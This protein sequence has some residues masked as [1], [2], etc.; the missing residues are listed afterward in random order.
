MMERKK[1][2]DECQRLTAE[3]NGV[4]LAEVHRCEFEA[5]S[6]EQLVREWSW[7]WDMVNLK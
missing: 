5:M 3:L 7:L 6:L 4:E 2:I 1:L